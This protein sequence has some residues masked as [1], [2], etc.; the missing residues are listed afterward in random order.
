MIYFTADL[1]FLHP[2]IVE[3]CNRP[4]DIEHHDKWLIDIWNSTVKKKDDVYIVGDVS[5]GSR[6]HTDKILDRLNGNKHLILGNHDNNIK[7]STRFG[8]IT[9]IKDFWTE[10]KNEEGK[11]TKFHIVLCHYP[12]KSW[13]RKVHGSAHLFGHVH[14][15]LEGDGL[16]FDVGIDANDYRILSLD[17]VLLKFT[18]IS[19]KLM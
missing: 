11:T 5:M 18:K 3:I 16:S 2:K 9:Q 6:L 14:G 13:N 19:M 4:T 7:N 8:T 15:R 17:D 1:H 10:V 12:M